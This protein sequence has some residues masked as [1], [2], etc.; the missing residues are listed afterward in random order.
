MLLA[1]CTPWQVQKGSFEREASEAGEDT[2]VWIFLKY[3]KIVP[4]SPNQPS[5]GRKKAKEVAKKLIELSKELFGSFLSK[6]GDSFHAPAFT[7]WYEEKKDKLGS[8]PIHRWSHG[9]Q[10]HLNVQL[11]ATPAFEKN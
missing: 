9:N 10:P 8:V 3:F 1:G 6:S 11:K 4:Y 5:T 2:D 7:A